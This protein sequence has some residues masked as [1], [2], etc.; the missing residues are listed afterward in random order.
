MRQA[1]QVLG[2]VRPARLVLVVVLVLALAIGFGAADSRYGKLTQQMSGDDLLHAERGGA[3]WTYYM[4]GARGTPIPTE[5]IYNEY[6]YYDAMAHPLVEG[7]AVGY[8]CVLASAIENAKLVLPCNA[9]AIVVFLDDAVLYT[10]LPG[11]Q[12]AP[13][14]WPLPEPGLYE[15]YGFGDNRV[16]TVSLPP[17][18]TGRT[19]TVVEYITAEAL[20]YWMPMTPFIENEYAERTMYLAGLAPTFVLAGML[21]AG[22][23]LLALLFCYQLLAGRPNWALLLPMAFLAIWAAS[24]A[25]VP[26]E[27]GFKSTWNVI[28]F[29]LA[30]VA[31]DDLLLAYLACKLKG[32]GRFGVFALAAGQLC[33][34]VGV[35]VYR[36]TLWRD[37]SDTVSLTEWYIGL[38]QLAGFVLATVLAFREWRQ[39]NRVLGV[40][41]RLF[42][43]F[44]GL[45]VVAVP[46][47]WLGVPDLKEYFIGLFYS[48]FEFFNF[49]PLLEAL[50]TFMVVS[51]LVISLYEFIAQ[52]IERNTTL[53]T[54]ELKN[55][56]AL[57]NYEN[58][59]AAIRQ[60]NIAQ[61]ELRNHTTA[62]QALLERQDYDRAGEYLR[63]WTVQ[64][65]G[66]APAQYGENPL[67]SA[68]VQNRLGIAAE[69]D[70]RTDCVVAVPAQLPV[71]DAE[72]CSLLLNMLDNAIEANAHLPRP[73]RWLRLRINGQDGMLAVICQNAWDGRLK[74]GPDGGLLSTKAEGT[75]PHGYGIA[76]MQAVAEAHGSL[77]DIS[78]DDTAF[79]VQTCLQIQ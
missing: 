77:L 14:H 57:E 44:A 55:R 24:H 63:Q 60:T 72:L 71:P 15:A 51:I 48:T 31:A 46:V 61:H 78:Y 30:Y 56:L 50:S 33:L 13:D 68:I 10:D 40:Y 27:F 35:A 11:Q 39:G 42:I 70:I 58:I 53:Q 8:S 38:P 5:I 79:T 20:P 66:L 18:Y 16:I 32:R 43:V 47:A 6:G 65:S 29:S 64:S 28:L 76:A 25:E 2:Q 67:V 59:Q 34:S 17:D 73:S 49:A 75:A 37:P 36:W 21:A 4:G 23:L 12:A 22:L 41:C 52:Q 1:R 62:L 3:G 26:D 9:G 74:A 45:A 7:Q 69:L 19:L 54:L